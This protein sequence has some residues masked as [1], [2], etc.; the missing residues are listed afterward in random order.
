MALDYHGELLLLERYNFVSNKVTVIA[1]AGVNHNG[2]LDYAYKLI[3]IAAKSKADIVKFQITN[4]K[5]ITK[6]AKKAKYQLS[7]NLDETQKQMI[8][9]LEM[10]WEKINP[11]L[12]NYSIK[13]NIKFLT[14][15]FDKNGLNHLRKLKLKLFKVPS[16]E[17][18][19]HPYLKLLGS[20]KTKVILSTGMANMGEIEKA[21][22]ILTSQGTKLNN[23]T[24]LQCNTAYPTPFSDVNLKVLETFKKNFGTKIGYSDHTL[25]IEAS[26]A[27]VA[28]GATVIEKH[29]TISRKLSG[30]DHQTSLDP[31]TLNRLIV[32]IRNIEKALG[33]NK[34]QVTKSEKSN[35]L[36]VRQSIV[37]IKKIE[38]GE[39]FTEN[40]ITLK[41]PG[42]GLKPEKFETL[43][44]RKAK[45]KFN[46]DD[47][48]SF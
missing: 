35:L 7:K 36:I 37:A 15:A 30:P 27:A 34:K 22:K 38:K 31:D 41:R 24:L 44:G 19:N 23:I 48:I 21:I 29:F 9:K 18:I 11:K 45:R 25:G 10:N 6:N 26:I 17:I 3:D 43:I 8:K 32:S 28:L 40:N 20:F 33:S 1:E 2:R 12:M 47:L 14:T 16:G 39:K 46:P 42:T 4:S 13:K 5:L